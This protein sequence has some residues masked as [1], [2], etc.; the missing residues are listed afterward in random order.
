MEMGLSKPLNYAVSQ[1]PVSLY[2]ADFDN[3]GDSDLVTVNHLSDNLSILLN[4]T[5]PYSTINENSPNEPFMLH[6][7]TPNPF[8]TQTVIGYTLSEASYVTIDIYDLIGRR[9]A[10]LVSSHQPAGY[11]QIQWN[12]D[13][14]SSGV[15]FYVARIGEHASTRRMILLQ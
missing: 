1:I 3:D 8:R 14:T 2:S 13:R 7:N 6:Q 11:H 10:S 12:S 15:Y 9:I 5:G 4:L